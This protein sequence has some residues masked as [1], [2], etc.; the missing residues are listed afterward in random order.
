MEYWFS[1][2]S[3]TW[4]ICVFQKS[5]P[6]NALLNNYTVLKSELY[7]S[8]TN[9]HYNFTDCWAVCVGLQSNMLDIAFILF[10]LFTY[11][12][13]GHC[14]REMGDTGEDDLRRSCWNHQVTLAVRWHEAFFF[15]CLLF[16]FPT[17]CHHPCRIWE[18]VKRTTRQA[19]T[20]ADGDRLNIFFP[21][22]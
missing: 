13:A 4:I 1:T 3:F 20:E 22:L 5:D 19:N 7:W 17:P 16:Y 8:S 21:P 18:T 14:S 2:H 11:L 12:F 15:V 10:I 9:W 6:V